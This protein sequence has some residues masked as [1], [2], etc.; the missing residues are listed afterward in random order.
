MVARKAIKV[1]KVIKKK[2]G[3]WAYDLRI[4]GKFERWAPGFIYEEPDFKEL[5]LKIGLVDPY[6]VEGNAFHSVSSLAEARKMCNYNE[7]VVVMRIPKGSYFYKKGIYYVS[8]QIYYPCNQKQL[9]R[10]QK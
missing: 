10:S 4:R 8:S 2:G 3:G 1:Y 6:R 9:K 7:I 5:A